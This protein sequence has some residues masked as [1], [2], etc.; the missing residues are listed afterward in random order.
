MCENH[1]SS[2]LKPCQRKSKQDLT[3][4]LRLGSKSNFNASLGAVGSRDF[5]NDDVDGFVDKFFPF[6]EFKCRFVA[7]DFANPANISPIF[8]L[9]CDVSGYLFIESDLDYPLTVDNCGVDIRIAVYNSATRD[10]RIVGSV[11]RGNFIIQDL[12]AIS[13]SN[14]QSE[15]TRGKGTRNSRSFTCDLDSANTY[16]DLT[17]RVVEGNR[18]RSIRGNLTTGRGC[19]YEV[20]W[21]RF[22]WDYIII[23]AAASEH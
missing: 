14:R 15:G 19:T 4:R 21:G 8:S 11:R 23:A 5:T 6:D 13:P 9:E 20:S 10:T 7:F 3:L 16:P 1:F 17:G 12:G 22:I 18:N 2:L